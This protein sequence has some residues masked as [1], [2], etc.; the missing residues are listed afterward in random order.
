M[1]A[2]I[3]CWPPLARA[4]ELKR[5]EGENK[6][7]FAVTFK[8][9][10]AL[11][12]ADW[13][14][15]VQH[16]I[17]SSECQ[18]LPLTLTSSP[19]VMDINA[20]GHVQTFTGSVAFP[21]AGCH[22]TFDIRYKLSA[23]ETTWQ[24]VSAHSRTAK[25]ELVFEPPAAQTTG[26]TDLKAF[27]DGL[28][29][30]Y[31]ISSLPTNQCCGSSL[32]KIEGRVA[33]TTSDEP[34]VETQVLGTFKD[35][36]RFS[37]VVREWTPW[38]KPQHGG[39]KFD[40]PDDALLLS[41]LRKDGSHL[42]LL[43]LSGVEDVLT[44]LQSNEKGEVVI[45]SKN[46]AT[47]E[48]GFI[49]VAAIAPSFDAATCAVVSEARK[50]V[51][52]SSDVSVDAKSDKEHNQALNDCWFDGLTY[53][54]WN[55][56][57]QNLTSENLYAGLKSLRDSGIKISNLI[58]D[59]CWQAVD[60][61]ADKPYSLRRA[62]DFEADPVFFPE[63]LKETVSRIRK[64]NPQIEN[65]SVWHALMGYWN[66]ISP[67]GKL[68]KKY[69]TN[70][71]VKLESEI[72]LE[73]E[74]LGGPMEIIDGSDVHRFYDDFYSFLSDAG[75]TA[76][77]TDVQ[78][79]VDSIVG[80]EGRRRHCKPFQDAWAKAVL[81]HFNG[82]AISCM[83][84]APQIVFHS[85]LPNNRP[86]MLLRTSDDFF[87]EIAESH[88][89]HVFCN[90][91][92]SLLAKHLNAIPDWDM[93]QSNHPYASFH[94]AARCVS[95]GPVYITD[96]PSKHDFNVVNQM[97][98]QTPSGRTIALRPSVLGTANGVYHKYTDGGVLAV[99]SYHGEAPNGTG[100]FGFFNVSLDK[101]S[102]HT[103][104]LREFAGVKNGLEYVI[105][106]YKGNNVSR[107]MCPEEDTAAAT[108]SLALRDW[109]IY[110]A[111]RVH[112]V[113]GSKVAVIGLTDKMTGPAAV[114][115]Y[116]VQ[117][118]SQDA[119]EVSAQLKAFGVFGVFVDTLDKKTVA[120][121]VAVTLN[122]RTVP[123]EFVAIDAEKKM[124]TVAVEKA[125]AEMKLADEKI[126]VTV[127][128]K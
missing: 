104:A 59:D 107:V 4:T 111:H 43:A 86:R 72:H 70:T 89:W 18:S 61:R 77:K 34:H 53:C 80:A 81:R 108:L 93:F 119:V 79:H 116:K 9:N 31:T 82:R 26:L 39:A 101:E 17:A 64:E 58:I 11:S 14:V 44:V 110:T 1:F 63:G 46:D 16:D 90:A 76:V 117:A 54:T 102:K 103:V 121:N 73:H 112:T 96:Y 106:E 97:T 120:D 94:A 57:S 7:T 68:A 48:Q 49:V 109:D 37:A 87:P 6:L 3:T 126:D 98:A 8:S 74:Q 55:G 41:F 19:A 12:P 20:S 10:E 115:G 47:E 128:L 38:L 105:R 122:G 92:T 62:V 124:V 83:S 78:F 66:G 33:G 36:V 27:A 45:S 32:W 28:D 125:W 30:K 60:H 29:G 69:K 13:V 15:E 88:P 21:A 95:G 51:E 85:Q 2:D 24:Y 23:S 127:L 114:L 65:V 99:S 22:A 56:L 42:A 52:G 40:C 113:C 123:A 71:V 35:T 91:H 50:I 67:E 25:G 118:T 75:I 84:Q 5:V 100:I